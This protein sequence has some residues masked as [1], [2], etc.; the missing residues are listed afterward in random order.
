MQHGNGVNRVCANGIQG[1]KKQRGGPK[2]VCKPP[3]VGDLHGPSSKN[4]IEAQR[5]WNTAQLIGVTTSNEEA[6]IS[7]LRKSKWLM[8]LEE[9]T[10]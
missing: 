5:T 3:K 2:K 8:L 7:E 4:L 1:T 10:N 6:V 9:E